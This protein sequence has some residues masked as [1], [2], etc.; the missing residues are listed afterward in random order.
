MQIKNKY[1]PNFS[2]NKRKSKDIKFLVIHYTGMQSKIESIVRLIDPK[3][4]VSCHYLI[5]ITSYYLFQYMDF[6]MFSKL[7]SNH[8]FYSNP[9]F[10]RMLGIFFLTLKNPAVACGHIRASHGR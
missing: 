7:N 8:K 10:D 1:S 9:A 2:K 6:M 5:A 3:F 4:K